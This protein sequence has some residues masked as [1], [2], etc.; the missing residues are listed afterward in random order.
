[1]DPWFRKVAPSVSPTLSLHAIHH[2][3]TLACLHTPNSS[4]IPLSKPFRFQTRGITYCLCQVS[5]ESQAPWETYKCRVPSSHFPTTPQHTRSLNARHLP[6][7]LPPVGRGSLPPSP[8]IKS[9]FS[10]HL[11]EGINALV[12]T[13]IQGHSSPSASTSCERLSF[14]LSPPPNPPGILT[15]GKERKGGVTQTTTTHST[16]AARQSKNPPPPVSMI[17]IFLLW[18]IAWALLQL[19]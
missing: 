14:H 12:P 16:E 18:E 5:R 11:E 2:H 9:S 13:R 1:M 17:D 4:S 15:Q 8:F 7:L 3:S 10:S 6:W 19:K